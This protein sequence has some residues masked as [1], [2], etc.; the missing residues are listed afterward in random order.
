[1]YGMSRMAA[2]DSL[3]TREREKWKFAATVTKHD[4]GHLEFISSGFTSS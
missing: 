2:Q 4:C 3:S 1:M